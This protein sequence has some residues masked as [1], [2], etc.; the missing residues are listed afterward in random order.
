MK[1]DAFV[2]TAALGLACLVPGAAQVR[3]EVALRAATE[4]EIVKGDV[5]GALA[6]YGAIAADRQTA[7]SIRAQALLRLAELQGKLGRPMAV[8]SF[9]RVIRDFPDQSDATAKARVA[10]E[11]SKSPRALSSATIREVA[12]GQWGT[13]SRDGAYIARLEPRSGTVVLHDVGTGAERR[14]TLPEASTGRA[15]NPSLSPDARQLA[16]RWFP[17]A[18]GGDS[19]AELRIASLQDPVSKPRTVPLPAEVTSFA[20]GGWAPDGQS[21]ALSVAT[22]ERALSVA[23]VDLRSHALRLIA[24]VVEWPAGARISFSPD[25]A[26]LLYDEPDTANQRPERDLVIAPVAGGPAQRVPHPSHDVAVGWNP[27]GEAVFASNRTGGMSLFALPVQGGTAAGTPR[28]IRSDVTAVA[29]LG[30]TASGTILYASPNGGVSDVYIVNADLSSGETLGDPV[31][32]IPHY[33]GTNSQPDFSPDGRSLAYVSRRV[34][35]IS[36]AIIGVLDLASGQLRELRPDLQVASAL[37]WG[38][39]GTFIAVTGRDFAGREGLFRIELSSGRSSLLALTSDPATNAIR[40]S[41]DGKSLFFR[42]IEPPTYTIVRL[43]LGTGAVSD[44]VTG[45]LPA[46]TPVLSKDGRMI[47]YRRALPG[48]SE[49]P[50]VMFSPTEPPD[51]AAVIERELATGAERELYRGRVGPLTLSPDGR[52]LVT[53][54]ADP[55]SKTRRSVTI[56]LPSGTVS[57]AAAERALAIGGTW[58]VWTRDGGALLSAQQS[59]VGGP[60]ELWWWPLDSRSPRRLTPGGMA[61]SGLSSVH[62]DG[63]RVAVTVQAAPRWTTYVIENLSSD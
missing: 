62:P 52:L 23:T 13:V 32:P 57:T 30:V 42:R 18:T 29:P 8:Q 7:R 63:R 36:T 41:P 20:L 12:S 47:Y 59:V 17:A 3:P 14:V 24:R 15:G 5:E 55:V 60:Y 40:W 37:R 10:L 48:G 1:A 19:R 51:P 9:Q 21:I 39:D 45:R 28:L 43:D 38:P 4:L 26:F 54:D 27:N 22:R 34:G 2:I 50:P 44:I 25:G 35:L 49:A 53:G 16:Y 46:A 31:A 11:R 33:V 58:G 61:I 6:A 56:E